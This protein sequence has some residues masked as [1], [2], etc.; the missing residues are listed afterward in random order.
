[1]PKLFLVRPT[2][3]KRGGDDA[4]SMMAMMPVLM[5]SVIVSNVQIIAQI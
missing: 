4:V 2:N 1:M 5:M 3:R